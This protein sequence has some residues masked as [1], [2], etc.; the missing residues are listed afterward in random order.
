MNFM[1]LFILSVGFISLSSEQSL[2]SDDFIKTICPGTIITA[3]CPSSTSVKYTI[4]V[5]EALYGI[6]GSSQSGCI[7]R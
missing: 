7:H 3:T 4:F 6:K 5:E 2:V 1:L